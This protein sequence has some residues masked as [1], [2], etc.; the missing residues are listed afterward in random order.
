M[1]KK[2]K[3]VIADLVID[4][5]REENT[6]NRVESAKSIISV[7]SREGLEYAFLFLI[8][9]IIEEYKED[10]ESLEELKRGE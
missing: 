3:D 8:G 1:N 4:L 7:L 10:R 5:D 9:V 2:S 6:D